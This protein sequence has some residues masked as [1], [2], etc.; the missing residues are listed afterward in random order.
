MHPHPQLPYQDLVTPDGKILSIE[1][2]DEKH[3]RAVVII[4]NVSPLFLGFSLGQEKIF[5]NLKSAIAQLGVNGIG[6]E[7]ELSLSKREAR[8]IVDLEATDAVGITL[9]P[10]LHP[11]A[12]I[13]KL[14]AADERRC[15]RSTTYLSSMLKR[16]DREGTPLFSLVGESSKTLHGTLKKVEGRVIA[17]LPLKR[18]IRTYTQ[19][20]HA[21]IPL[22]A[23]ALKYPGIRIRELL[24]LLQHWKD[25]KRIV[26]DNLLLVNTLPLYIRIAFGHVVN[27]LLPKGMQHT[28]ASI[29][30]PETRASGDIYEVYGSSGEEL[31]TIPLEFY[32]LHP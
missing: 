1:K 4:E 21:M 17:F 29:L 27:E 2:I 12:Y 16:V 31:H 9:L 24:R 14:F 13:G 30:D 11:H 20:I 19:E 8:V 3:Y 5:F 28:T 22:F 32:A 10:C 15:I 18:G 25:S 7:Y 23:H 6:K 26:A